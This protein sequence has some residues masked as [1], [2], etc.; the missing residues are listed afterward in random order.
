[1]GLMPMRSYT[2]WGIGES[3]RYPAF[4]DFSWT[5]TTSAS[6]ISPTGGDE[7]GIAVVVD[8]DDPFAAGKLAV[9]TDGAKLVLFQSPPGLQGFRTNRLR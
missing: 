5:A 7:A 8:V 2:P 4:W 6:P 3:S 1:M 9:G